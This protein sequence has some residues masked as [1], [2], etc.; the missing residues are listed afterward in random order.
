MKQ[1]I[2]PV[3]R[4]YGEIAIPP[5]KSISHRAVMLASIADGTST[6]VQPLLSAD[7]LR[8]IAAFRSM[9]VAV[10]VEENNITIHGK[11]LYGLQRPSTVID[12]GNSGT[13]I[14]LLMG[15]L[16][17]QT[18]P[19]VLMGDDSIARRPMGRVTEPLKLME[20]T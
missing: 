7:V 20:R 8:T 6:I 14:R 18:F 13:T 12:V 4:L 19:T 11:G 10:D 3:Q 17:A 5:D 1:E 9:G 15:I 16:A 2:V